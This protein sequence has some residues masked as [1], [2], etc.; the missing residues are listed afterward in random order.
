M[1][2]MLPIAIG[3]LCCLASST[4]QGSRPLLLA[5]QTWM[6]MEEKQSNGGH[7][8][9]IETNNPYYIDAKTVFYSLTLPAGADKVQPID[10]HISMYRQDGNQ[11]WGYVQSPVGYT[12][13][14]SRPTSESTL[15]HC[16]T[17]TGV[18]TTADKSPDHIDGLHFYIVVPESGGIYGNGCK[19][20]R[21]V[22]TLFVDA[23][24][25]RPSYCQPANVYVPPT[26]HLGK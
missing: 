22:V 20:D 2:K 12:V 16:A 15:N 11:H 14:A 13:C 26:F 25:G 6:F 9:T 7:K 5:T 19:V 4:A 10:P 21:K 17:L 24:A 8:E 1:K 23:S 18:I 3:A